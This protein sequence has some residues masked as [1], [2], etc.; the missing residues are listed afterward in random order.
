MKSTTKNIRFNRLTHKNKKG[1]VYQVDHTGKRLSPGKR[2]RSQPYAVAPKFKFFNNEVTYI[3]VAH[4][5][6]AEGHNKEIY[7]T[8]VLPL[9]A[10]SFGA[11]I[12]DNCLLIG[13]DDESM[14][15]AAA[16]MLKDTLYRKHLIFSRCKIL[17]KKTNQYWFPN[18]YFSGGGSDFLST[19]CRIDERNNVTYIP[20]TSSTDLQTIL[21]DIL[22]REQRVTETRLPVSKA[23]ITANPDIEVIHRTIQTIME[24]VKNNNFSRAHLLL[25][26][27]AQISEAQES[28]VRSTVYSAFPKQITV[29]TTPKINIIFNTCM[30]GFEKVIDT[31]KKSAAFNCFGKHYA[32]G[33]YKRKS[34]RKKKRKSKRKSKRK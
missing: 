22:I 26:L 9:D 32:A 8:D 17:N 13:R 16:R 1:I 2:R 7:S 23:V 20:L 4:G 25:S 34:H 14:Q 5:R 30:G 18:M 33:I 27:N 29:N 11:L 12:E 15:Q 19:L 10:F 31:K 24:E 3:I 28:D 21:I 6:A